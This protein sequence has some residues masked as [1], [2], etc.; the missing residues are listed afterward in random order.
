MRGYENTLRKQDAELFTLVEDDVTGTF[1]VTSTIPLLGVDGDE[2]SIGS[3]DDIWLHVETIVYWL[4]KVAIGTGHLTVNPS[5]SFFQDPRVLRGLADAA[6]PDLEYVHGLVDTA[7]QAESMIASSEQELRLKVQEFEA[8]IAKT[9]EDGIFKSA[10]SLWSEKAKRHT[11]AYTIGFLTIVALISAFPVFFSVYQI[12][13][14]SLLPKNEHT[15]E[16]TYLAALIVALGFVAL[17]WIFRMLG[18]FVI[19]NFSLASDARQREM[20]LRTF[21]TLVGTPEAKMQDGERVL[22]LNAIF[23][24]VPGQGPDDPA[25][26]S[27]M[28]LMKDAFKPAGK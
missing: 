18:R 11:W 24:P 12:N 7:H 14:W 5:V 2:L 15:G 10:N 22:I 19:D 28:D 1:V 21:L 4:S 13:M 16:Y 26:S 27:L 25:P 20:I 9:R 23:R 8:V 17:A 6:T 3:N